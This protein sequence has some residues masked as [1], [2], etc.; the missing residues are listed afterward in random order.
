MKQLRYVLAIVLA[1]F[2]FPVA[3]ASSPVGN[4]L[5]TD[6]K[7]GK[8]RAEV[9]LDIVKGNLVGQIVR[10]FQQ[11]GDTGLCSKCPDPFK[12]KPIQGLQF[13]WGCSDNGHGVWSGGRILDAKTGKIYRVKLKVRNDKLYIRGYV[14][15]SMLGRT[16]VWERIQDN[17]KA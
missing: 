4:W 12:D 9:R 8:K 3:L 11:P 16:Q 15:F 6:D 13:L 2:Y 5:T 1:L 14:G 10:V 7:T 17:K